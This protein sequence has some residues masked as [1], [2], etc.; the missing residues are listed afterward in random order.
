L[1]AFLMTTSRRIFVRTGL[2][3]TLFAAVPYKTVLAQSWKQRDGNPGN[4]PPLQTDPL[5]N[6]SEAAFES[7]LNSVFQLHTTSGIVAV[8]LQ[9]VS[10]MPAVKNG[11]CFSLV[12]R[13]GVT[14]QNQATYTLV[15]D[16]LGAMQLFLVPAGLEKNGTPGY[17]ATVNRL[18]R[19]AALQAGVPTSMA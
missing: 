16:A 2:L 19:I 18:S 8:T 9:E 12:F 17:V 14:S 6:Y 5:S 4:I 10:S 13:G 7:Y 11:E 3:A 1:E 15:H